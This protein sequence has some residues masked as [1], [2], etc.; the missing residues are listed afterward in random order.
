MGIILAG[1]F[2][3]LF[4]IYP[5]MFCAKKLGAEKH[6]LIDC[7]LA[8]IVSTLVVSILVPMLPSANTS[9]EL[10]YLYGFL[11]SGLVFKF[12]LQAN[13]FTSVL[14]AL[15]STILRYVALF[16]VTLFLPGT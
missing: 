6:D 3:V 12:M 14:I 9:N 13:Y 15:T 4:C 1:L 10:S 2:V 8:I 16:I 7:L 11:V 5:V